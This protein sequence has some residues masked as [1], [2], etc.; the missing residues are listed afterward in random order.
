MSLKKLAKVH[1]N[2]YKIDPDNPLYHTIQLSEKNRRV[3]GA[4][5]NKIVESLKENDALELRPII[6]REKNKNYEV[7]D[8]QHRIIAARI[9]GIP[10][11]VLLNTSK[12][13]KTLITL[14]T[15]QRN[16]TLRDFAKY[17]SQ[18]PE[19]KEVYTKFLEYQ[20]QYTITFNLLIAVF[21]MKTHSKDG[22]VDYKEGR[23][24]YDDTNKAHIEETLTKIDK[25]RFQAMNPSLSIR[26]L[27]K[28]QF[29]QALLI[30]FKAP[31][32]CFQKFLDNLSRSRHKFNILAKQ[33]DFLAEIY[34]IESRR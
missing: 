27:Q 6:V 20:K 11:Y 9:L 13:P 22:A 14:N 15:N 32:F 34:R 24:R 7:D 1:S 28:Q 12:N 17:W 25:L 10:Y 18:Q 2:I 5:V 19:T 30:A 21:R 33:T 8:G 4:N 29:Q 16:W 23:L 31:N 3:N 26:T